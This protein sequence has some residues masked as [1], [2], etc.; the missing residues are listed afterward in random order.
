MMKNTQSELPGSSAIQ[1]PLD[2]CL[3]GLSVRIGDVPLFDNLSH[4]FPCAQWSCLLG[5]SGVGKSMLLRAVLGLLE[6]P[7]LKNVTVT[8]S[9]GSSEGRPITNQIAYMAQQDLLLPWLSV[10][11]NVVIG[12]RLRKDQPINMDHADELLH[13]TGL[14]SRANDL[15]AQLSGGMRQRVALA[16]TLWEDKPIVLMD[17]P[18]SA[19]DAISRLHAQDLAFRLLAGR[20]V[21][22]VTHDPLEAIRLAHNITILSGHP[23]T[24]SPSLSPPGT[25]PRAAD[26]ASV[27]NLQGQLL[28]QLSGAPHE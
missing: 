23:A 1:S 7:A 25:A 21:L 8:G 17:E 18:F 16:R 12:G 2:I 28:N 22:M 26:D 6:A 10:R 19:L 3:A 4:C 24:L 5:T 20:T 27:L 13:L 15:P 9:I 14:Q 11:E